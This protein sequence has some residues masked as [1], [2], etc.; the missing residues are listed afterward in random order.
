MMIITAPASLSKCAEGVKVVQEWLSSGRQAATSHSISF[1]SQPIHA[2]SSPLPRSLFPASPLIAS[3][4]FK[5]LKSSLARLVHSSSRMN[6]KSIDGP[7]T[8]KLPI[9]K[10][11]TSAHN[12]THSD[13]SSVP[14]QDNCEIR[15]ENIKNK[16][17]KFSVAEDTGPAKQEETADNKIEDSYG[18]P[19]GSA[20][21]AAPDLAS[22]G[23]SNASISLKQ[24]RIRDGDGYG[25]IVSRSPYAGPSP[26]TTAVFTLILENENGIDN[27]KRRRILVS[28]RESMQIGR[29]SSKNDSGPSAA[30]ETNAYINN[31]MVSRHHAELSLV[32]SPTVRIVMLLLVH[33]PLIA[34]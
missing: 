16:R 20:Y 10:I 7:A 27:I 6:D 14:K 15:E 3:Y 12:P 19:S 34:L 2:S 11:T 25:G 30:S 24:P 13:V 8:T 17:V 18:D 9:A 28:A 21:N 5:S 32:V 31:S 1:H 33:T 22:S 26:L 23:A 4:M 29:A